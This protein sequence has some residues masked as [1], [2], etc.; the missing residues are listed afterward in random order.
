LKG[1]GYWG[2]PVSFK[3]LKEVI[4]ASGV[5]RNLKIVSPRKAKFTF[6]VEWG[7]SLS[8]DKLFLAIMECSALQV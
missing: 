8:N 1:K 4:L 3:V 5:F 2:I 6:E 7:V